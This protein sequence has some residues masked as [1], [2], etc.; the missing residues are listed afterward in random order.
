MVKLPSFDGATEWLNS[1]PLTPQALQAALSSSA[2]A[3][4]PASTGSVP[5]LTCGR[6]QISTRPTGWR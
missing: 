1:G 6:G 2:S 4:T 3:R 5:C